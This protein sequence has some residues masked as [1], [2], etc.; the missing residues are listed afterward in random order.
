MNKL[1]KTEENTENSESKSKKRRVI[2]Q[3]KTRLQ[4][5]P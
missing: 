1:K 4:L 5:K 3:L 2:T